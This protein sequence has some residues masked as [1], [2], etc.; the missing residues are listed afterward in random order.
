M[1]SSVDE[2]TQPIQLAVEETQVVPESKSRLRHFSRY[3]FVTRKSAGVGA[4]IVLLFL[5]AA[6][7]APLIAPYDPAEQDL[8]NRYSPPTLDHPLGTDNFGRDMLS[9]VIYGAR[10][11]L[12]V[13]VVAVF[14]SIFVGAG[15][16][17]IAG[18]AGGKVDAVINFFIEMLMTF[19]VLLLALVLIAVL[20]SGFFNLMLAIGL[21][22]VPL[23]AR[24]M[25]AETTTTK[26][27]D[28][29]LAAFGL[30]ATYWR[31]IMRHI[32][33][34]VSSTLI[35]LSTTR[36]ATAILSES[37]L[38]FLGLGIQPPTPSWGVM[39]TEGRAFLETAPWIA[40]VP[41]I[42]IM[43]TVLGFNLF[44]DGL[45]DALDVRL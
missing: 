36:I 26:Q 40:L 24:V 39:I 38:S 27:R 41:G 35:V 1:T 12:V 5:V 18:Y 19:P 30:G 9:R 8:L 20:G 42:A 16:G 34:N 32:V 33:P 13:G 14:I 4:I 10:I 3:I 25:R 37:A 44:G 11:S 29:V 23:F 15:L 45:R 22:S 7:A 28:Y 6:V 17:I 43:I 2:Y 21:G 31:I